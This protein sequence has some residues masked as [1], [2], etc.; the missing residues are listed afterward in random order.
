MAASV[1]T[2]SLCLPDALS[3]L[4]FWV[5]GVSAQ[6]FGYHSRG[7]SNHGHSRGAF[8]PT[9][10]AT[11]VSTG[12]VRVEGLPC[13]SPCHP[14]FFG[15]SQVA[16]FV[17]RGVGSEPGCPSELTT[18][19][20]LAARPQ[21]TDP[22]PGPRLLPSGC[23]LQGW[24]DLAATSQLKWPSAFQLRA[25]WPDSLSRPLLQDHCWA[26]AR[27]ADSRDGLRIC[28]QHPVSPGTSR[29][30]APGL[31]SSAPCS[32]VSAGSPRPSNMAQHLS[33]EA[34]GGS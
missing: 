10:M 26:L 15:C 25:R 20:H 31:G 28:G 14:L 19:A 5:A 30:T 16:P 34:S 2:V 21:T 4:P 1:V 12:P 22:T 13:L 9:L 11:L 33:P 32:K 23:Q 7:V 17:P 24:P 29:L 8:Q 6:P 27:L 18:K 3:P